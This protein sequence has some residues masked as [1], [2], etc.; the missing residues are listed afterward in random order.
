M[1]N[2]LNEFEIVLNYHV[3]FSDLEGFSLQIKDNG[4]LINTITGRKAKNL[5]ECLMSK[6][7]SVDCEIDID[8]EIII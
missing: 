3:N 8:E 6:D 4:R 1:A 7:G 2:V 5:Y